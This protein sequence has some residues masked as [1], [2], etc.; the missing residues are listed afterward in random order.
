MEEDQNSSIDEVAPQDQQP[1]AIETPVEEPEESI[2]KDD[3]EKNWREVRRKQKEFEYQLK[4]KDELIEKLLKSSTTP[5]Q[6]PKEPEESIAEDDFPTWAQTQKGIE[7]HASKIAEQ[8]YRELEEKKEQSRFMERLSAKYSDFSD[9]VNPDSIA[10]FEEKD[11]E[12]AAT[13]ADLKDP[14][15]MGLQT[16][17][18]IKAMNISDEVP[19]KRHEREVEKKLEKN[20]KT[21][22]SPQAYNKRPM[23]QAFKLTE[24]DKK[25]L[26]TEMMQYATGSGY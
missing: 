5:E 1:E 25:A 19:A 21:V 16:Y 8:K 18:F 2:K 9:I 11:P 12:L 6:A 7:K 17:R 22:Q 24:S 14:Y 10:I 3:Q 13:I 23:A 26:Y 20:E 15:K 4:M